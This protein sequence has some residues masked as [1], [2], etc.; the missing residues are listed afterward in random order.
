MSKL[1]RSVVVVADDHPVVLGGLITLLNEDKTFK[2]VA[3]C[4]NGAEAINAI[5]ALKPDLAFLTSTCR[6]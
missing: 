3:T 1:P 2:V 6:L 5:R 4:G